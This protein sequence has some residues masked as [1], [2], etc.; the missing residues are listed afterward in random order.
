MLEAISFPSSSALAQIPSPALQERC[1]FIT[2]IWIPEFSV[3]SL[4]TLLALNMSQKVPCRGCW[5][6]YLRAHSFLHAFR[7]LWQRSCCV[8]CSACP[9]LFCRTLASGE[10]YKSHFLSSYRWPREKSVPWKCVSYFW[11]LF[12]WGF[13]SC[14]LRYHRSLT[15]LCQTVLF[16]QVGQLVV[17]GVGLS[18]KFHRFAWQEMKTELLNL[19][20]LV[21]YRV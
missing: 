6:V 10:Q 3:E 17:T 7:H 4:S 8:Q 1:F 16:S 20:Y 12:F 14:P 19:D 18:V 9:V 11:E 2:L 15:I 5:G 21:S 13:F